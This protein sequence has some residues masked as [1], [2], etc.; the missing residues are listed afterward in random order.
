MVQLVRFFKMYFIN[1]L[2][3]VKFTES[4]EKILK[5]G[6]LN[7]FF[8]LILTDIESSPLFK[9]GYFLLYSGE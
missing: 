8:V 4:E 9:G 5:F 7:L 1:K 6:F 2:K 3:F